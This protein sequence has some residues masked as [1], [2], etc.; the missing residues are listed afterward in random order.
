MIWN[1]ERYRAYE[2]HR[3]RPASDL[4][5]AVGDQPFRRIVDL[6]CGPGN[7]TEALIRAFP[8]AAVTA[9]DAD[10][11]MV[12]AARKRLPGVDV[13]L[14]DLS[15][16]EAPEDVDLFF[17]NALFHWVPGHMPLLERLKAKLN[18]GGV[19]AIQMPDNLDEP[20]HRLMV[21]TARE[22][23]WKQAFAAAG[24]PKRAAL[25]APADYV[26]TLSADGADVSVWRTTYF[27]RMEN[28]AAIVDF[29]GGAGLRPYAERIR[30]EA[31][32][33]AHDAWFAAYSAA[34]SRA[35]PPL[36]DGSVLMPM[37]RLFVLV[38]KG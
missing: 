36:A 32:E 28:A 20:T 19:L 13:S 37:P 21:E 24:L 31:G 27:H 2:D 3:N 4:I 30:K 9:I 29:V 10:P 8:Q 16:W 26:E 5:H 6:G 7:S 15:S 23:F 12:E 14:A 17:A 38:R 25:P 1:P 35:Y 34:V 33:A 11:S 18:P 22:G